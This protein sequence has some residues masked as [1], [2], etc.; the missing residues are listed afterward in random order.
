M[1]EKMLSLHKRRILLRLICIAAATAVFAWIAIA[2]KSKTAVS[3]N[4]WIEP[5]ILTRK[6]IGRFTIKNETLWYR[7]EINK[8]YI[9]YTKIKYENAGGG[10]R[11]AAFSKIDVKQGDQYAHATAQYD[12][13]Y[14]SGSLTPKT[15]KY[16][17]V[18]KANKTYYRIEK[19][20]VFDWKNMKVSVITGDENGKHSRTKNIPADAV[21]ADAALLYAM[22]PG[23]LVNN[24]VY[25]ANVYSYDIEDFVVSD[26][27]VK[28]EKEKLYQL[29][30][31]FPTSFGTAV[32]TKQWISP[33]DDKNPNGVVHR[34]EIKEIG[35]HLTFTKTTEAK[36]QNKPGKKKKKK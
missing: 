9:G 24:R 35:F 20:I 4:D 17:E 14:E 1:P 10:I 21:S 23:N 19:E 6:N 34:F 15:I 8:D 2:F 27:K 32:D 5:I 31:S 12:A 11:F 18:M 29:I 7:G 13:L 33:P 28:K 16:K 26:I 36:A 25:R 22:R 3:Q 30:F